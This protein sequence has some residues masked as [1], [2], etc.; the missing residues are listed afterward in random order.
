M[1]AVVSLFR[2]PPFLVGWFSS[3][4]GGAWRLPFL[5][6]SGF[7]DPDGLLASLPFLGGS[8]VSLFLWGRVEVCPILGVGLERS[9]VEGWRDLSGKADAERAL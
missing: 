4:G 9:L 1:L 3:G 5:G 6:G 2:Y 8:G 7:L